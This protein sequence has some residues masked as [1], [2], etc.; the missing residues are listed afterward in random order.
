M[1]EIDLRDPKYPSRY[2]I[3]RAPEDVIR[4][5]TNHPLLQN[6][7]ITKAGYFPRAY[8][9]AMARELFDEYLVTY[10]LD[11]K[12]WLQFGNTHWDIGKG[13]VFFVIPGAP[14]TYGAINDDPWTIQWAVFRGAHVP[15]LLKF[16]GVSPENLVLSI[17]D[18]VNLTILFQDILSTLQ[19]GHSLHY[20][21]NAST[22][23]QQILSSIALLSTYS[24]STQNIDLNVD[25]AIRYMRKNITSS[26]TLNE[27]A[28]HACLSPSYF[29]Y[30]FRQ[31]TGYAPIDYF[32]RLK[33]QKACELLETTDWNVSKISNYLDYQDQFYFSRIFKKIMDVSPSQYRARREIRQAESKRA[34]RFRG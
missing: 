25:E 23:L 12:G 29:S 28:S 21:Y 10:C 5:C 24:P 2:K 20:L 30:R 15:E 18:R 32:I 22:S 34:A 4:Q 7:M 9:H 17:G 6:L 14:H 16:T 33:I 27:F 1:S 26:C 3:Y 13:Q 31:K 11:G 19:L 8:N